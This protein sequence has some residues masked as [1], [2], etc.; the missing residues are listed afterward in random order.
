MQL[1]NCTTLPGFSSTAGG[2]ETAQENGYGIGLGC[3]SYFVL[4]WLPS[5]FFPLSS[6]HS[7][8]INSLNKLEMASCLITHDAEYQ[9]NV[10]CHP[11]LI[12][13]SHS[14]SHLRIAVVTFNFKSA[15]EEDWFNYA[16]SNVVIYLDQKDTEWIGDAAWR[17]RLPYVLSHC[18]HAHLHSLNR[19]CQKS[20][21][22]I[23]WSTVSQ[24]S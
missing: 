15:A 24:V 9:R 4:S 7:V 1:L 2:L 8:Y 14:H 11:Y 5:R 3:N 19:G 12:D 21:C 10:E 17:K 20:L 6:F 23:D 16:Y 13:F 18:S 22:L